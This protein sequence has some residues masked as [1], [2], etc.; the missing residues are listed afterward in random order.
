MLLAQDMADGE[1][2]AHGIQK[3]SFTHQHDGPLGSIYLDL[4]PRQ[5][6]SC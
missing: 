3:Y 4:H 5:D 6:S 1:A 2:W